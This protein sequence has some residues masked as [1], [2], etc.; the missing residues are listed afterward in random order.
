M[1]HKSNAAGKKALLT[2][3]KYAHEIRRKTPGKKWATCIKEASAKY[4]KK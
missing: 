2:I 3:N 1:P 4:R